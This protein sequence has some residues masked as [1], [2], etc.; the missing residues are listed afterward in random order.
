MEQKPLPEWFCWTRF[1][2]EAGQTTEH[3]L[4]RKERERT[5]NGGVFI[6]GIGNALGPSIRELVARVPNPQVLFSPIKS[7]PKAQDVEPPAVAA[8]TAGETLDGND[9]CLPVH[10]LVTSRY[11]PSS[12]KETHYALVCFS[13]VPITATRLQDKIAFE[14]L[15]NIRTGRP[16][17]ASQVT[18][19]VHRRSCER[20]LR[21]KGAYDV[22]I[23]AVLVPP[24]FVKLRHP[25]VLPT[26]ATFQ[27]TNEEWTSH[28]FELV[29]RQRKQADPRLRQPAI[30]LHTVAREI[31]SI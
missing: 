28:A 11:D 1:G 20:S 15:M 31:T 26:P 3:I 29:D 27:A 19:V 7:Q 5:A 23:R 2:T 16:I 25:L 9:Y 13:D 24:Y 22:A 12:P 14:A 8:W 21:R 6:W 17:G 10:S 18:A 30:A 4:Q